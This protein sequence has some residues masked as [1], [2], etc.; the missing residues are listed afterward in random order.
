MEQFHLTNGQV[1]PTGMAC[2][3]HN[4]PLK[5]PCR[6]CGM[7]YQAHWPELNRAQWPRKAI[8]EDCSVCSYPIDSTQHQ[9][10]RR[11]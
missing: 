9:N 10:H 3:F 8:A 6:R 2:E 5:Q 7:T 4:G 1:A 11:G